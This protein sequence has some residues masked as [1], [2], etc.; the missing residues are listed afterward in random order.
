MDRSLT[1]TISRKSKTGVNRKNLQWQ[2]YDCDTG[3]YMRQVLFPK[4]LLRLNQ[5]QK[6]YKFYIL[7]YSDVDRKCITLIC[8]FQFCTCLFIFMQLS[9]YVHDRHVV[10][11]AWI[12]TISVYSPPYH[13]PLYTWAA[14]KWWKLLQFCIIMC[15]KDWI[16]HMPWIFHHQIV[17]N[18][19][20]VMCLLQNE[21]LTSL[22][23]KNVRFDFI[24]KNIVPKNLMSD[25]IS[26]KKIS[27]HISKLF[28]YFIFVY[29]YFIK[30]H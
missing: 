6:I 24:Q 15:K 7:G 8:Y 17:H 28:I 16:T 5:L 11:Y 1:S 26:H 10:I 4:C 3:K 19:N 2:Q 9:C 22:L 29:M 13:Y 30:M 18:C 27:I 12:Y 21:I 25:E 20:G 23:L 14:L